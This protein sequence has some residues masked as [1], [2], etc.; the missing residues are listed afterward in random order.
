MPGQFPLKKI[1]DCFGGRVSVDANVY[2]MAC[3]IVSLNSSNSDS[4]RLR[5]IKGA[6]AIRNGDSASNR[7][8]RA[9]RPR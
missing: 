7:E 9:P 6:P 4:G 3:I 5:R 2:D 8:D 1:I